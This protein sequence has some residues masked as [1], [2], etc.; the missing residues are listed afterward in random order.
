MTP[1]GSYSVP[2]QEGALLSSPAWRDLW[3]DPWWIASIA[4]VL[5]SALPLLVPVMDPDRTWTYATYWVEI[6]TT[7]LTLMIVARAQHHAGHRRE[8]LF[9]LMWC[10]ALACWLSNWWL[11]LVASNP[12][13]RTVEL[14]ADLANLMYYVFAF[15]AVTSLAHLRE[16]D[17]TSGRSYRPQVLGTILFAAALLAYFVVI[18]VV[19][20][21]STYSSYVP[22]YVMYFTLDV[23]LLLA[24][25]RLMRLAAGSAWHDL[26]L[27]LAATTACWLVL[28]TFEAL[29]W[30]EVIPWVDSGTP[31]DVPWLLPFLPLAAAALIQTRHPAPPQSASS[32]ESVDAASQTRS[33]RALLVVYASALPILHFGAYSLGS[34]DLAIRTPREVCVFLAVIALGFLAAQAH[35]RLEV[36]RDAIGARVRDQK[37]RLRALSRRLASAHENE[38]RQIA[39]ELHDEI[40]QRLTGLRLSLGALRRADDDKAAEILDH[41]ED[42]LSTLQKQVRDLSLMLR[43]SLLDDYGLVAALQWLFARF[44]EQ[45]GLAVEFEGPT[46]EL[47]MPGDAQVAGYRIVQEALT[48]VVR[49]AGVQQATV[50]LSAT[51]SEYRIEVSDRGR[52]FVPER[53]GAGEV[54]GLDGMRERAELLGGTL[55]VRSTPGSGTRV[56]LAMPRE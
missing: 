41:V 40:G 30:V 10:L 55:S 33:S 36:E 54:C 11:Y 34:G 24:F 50:V 25:V 42:D 23:L 8:R 9:W 17:D 46:E 53:L 49:H 5:L 51:P 52:G 28:D 44:N 35:H 48:N 56:V 29:Q 2:R 1:S 20:A 37:D 16:A 19:L 22:S 43:P 39:R 3:R 32:A 13:T 27:L 21:P 15:L 31:L 7:V 12:E 47:D 4:V 38:R 26:Y 6:P 45:M 14:V 18:P